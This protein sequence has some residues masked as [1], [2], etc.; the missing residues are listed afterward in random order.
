MFFFVII[1]EINKELIKNAAMENMVG[2]MCATSVGGSYKLFIYVY[3]IYLY[4]IIIYFSP[5]QTSGAETHM[6]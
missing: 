6:V 2:S 1:T 3:Y 5:H 4:H